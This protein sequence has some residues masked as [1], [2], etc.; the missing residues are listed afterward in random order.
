MR[1]RRPRQAFRSAGVF[2]LVLAGRT[3]AVHYEL[4]VSN[5]HALH[6]CWLHRRQ[7][8]DKP[9]LVIIHDFVFP[10]VGANTRGPPLCIDRNG[11]ASSCRRCMCCAALHCFGSCIARLSGLDMP[12]SPRGISHSGIASS[13]IR[14]P[15]RAARPSFGTSLESVRG[16]VRGTRASKRHRLGNGIRSC[17][18][19]AFRADRRVQVASSCR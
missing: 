18:P 1:S 7:L 15:C 6:E 9:S 16:S 3:V 2:C 8:L 10:S 4:H 5:W 12:R 11:T 19:S 13:C 17:N 14:Q